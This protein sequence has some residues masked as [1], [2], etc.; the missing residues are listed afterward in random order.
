MTYS[1]ET[2][3][4]LELLRIDM[5]ENGL[6][7]TGSLIA[8]NHAY[9]YTANINGNPQGAIYTAVAYPF[10]DDPQGPTLIG[11][12]GTVNGKEQYTYSSFQEKTNLKKNKAICVV[13]DGFTTKR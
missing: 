2:E 13:S 10:D 5:D 8:D 1:P 6:A 12:Y 3:V 11:W 7:P 9:T 4:D